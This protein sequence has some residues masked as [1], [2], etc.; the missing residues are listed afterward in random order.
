ME[1]NDSPQHCRPP[2]PRGAGRWVGGGGGKRHLRALWGRGGRRVPRKDGE[3]FALISPAA[4]CSV[5]RQKEKEKKEKKK[6]FIWWGDPRECIFQALFLSFLSFL[7]RLCPRVPV[8]RVTYM[9]ILA[10][11]CFLSYFTKLVGTVVSSKKEKEGD[12][13]VS[14]RLHFRNHQTLY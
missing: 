9:C 10:P 5:H 8:A 3:S 7:S 4:F 2:G 14:C 11:V 6:S 12:C 1:V 13:L